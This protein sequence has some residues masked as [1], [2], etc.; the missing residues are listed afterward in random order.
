VPVTPQTKF[1]IGSITKQFTAAAILRLQKQGKLN[2]ADKLVKFIPDYL[3][4]GEVTLHH[5]LTH[6]SGIHSYTSKPDFMNTVT[7]PVKPEDH[8][9]SFKNDPY[10]FAPGE[11]YLYNNSG[12]FLLGYIVE[13]VSGQSYADFLRH[14]FFTPLGMT[15]TGV[16]EATAVLKHEATGYA[17]LNGQ[18]RKAINWDMSR[19]GGAGALYSTVQDLFRWNEAVFGGKVLSAAILKPA[20]A[21]VLTKQDAELQG[22]KEIGYGYGWAIGKTRGLRVIDHGGGLHGFL[23]FLLRVP[24]KSMTVIV[25]ANA[26]EPPPG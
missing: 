13:K 22:Q 14:E 23:S 8:I 7:V 16:H 10:D 18:F 5:L 20:F 2:V 6:T 3:R 25:L 19:A 17:Y 4:G 1:R 9:K 11:K 21:P 26:S 15:N 12:F 24:A